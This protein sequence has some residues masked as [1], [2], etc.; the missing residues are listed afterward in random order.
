MNS[1]TQGSLGATVPDVNELARPGRPR[2]AVEALP[3]YRPGRDAKQAQQDHGVV[4]AVKLASNEN[5]EAPISAI[6]N[7]V[8]HAVRG[9]NRYADHR[10]AELRSHI[11]SWLGVNAEQVTIGNGSVGLLQQIF[12]TY[13]DAGD[14]IIFGW[15][16]F[17]VYPIFSQ[18]TGAEMVRV[19]LLD[20][21]T[22][23][24]DGIISA[25]SPATKV[26]M[27]ATPN[28]PTGT[29][30]A[31]DDIV[32]IASAAG[33]GV[34]V[35]IDEAYREFVDADIPDPVAEVVPHFRNVLVTRTLSKAHGLAG[36]RV[37]YAVGDAEVVAD[38]DKVAVPFHVNAAAQAAAIA[39]ID[40]I[41]EIE[42]RC[43]VIVKERG[44]V[45][46]QLASLG[47]WMPHHQANFVYLSTGVNTMHYAT[48]L[49]KRGVVV[50]PFDGEGIRVTIGSA[51]E[52]DRFLAA[53][54]EL[55]V[56]K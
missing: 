10:G 20:D 13:L 32:R 46:S 37:G 30:L 11:A 40:N 16:S 19:P 54:T 53:I 7:A 6:E 43:A 2:S 34:I 17:E 41:D 44:R 24:V 28:N 35:V 15:R 9:A 55:G 12:L 23:D 26:I 8:L 38:I 52:N 25:I 29:L 36:L 33:D 27:L 49:E 22:Y 48:E 31:A 56:V 45:E 21:L 14:E 4:D 50:R 1:R 51:A 39:A 42:A 18:L 5:P 47:W 3:A